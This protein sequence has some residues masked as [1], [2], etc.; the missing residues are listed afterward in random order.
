MFSDRPSKINENRASLFLHRRPTAS[1][2]GQGLLVPPNRAF[3]ITLQVLDLAEKLG[4]L[5]L[6]CFPAGL[7]LFVSLP[8]TGHRC[9]DHDNRQQERRTRWHSHFRTTDPNTG[10]RARTAFSRTE[11]RQGVSPRQQ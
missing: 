10:P 11:A 7:N 5:L 8:L 3:Q 2:E 4:G 6:K 1:R 9:R